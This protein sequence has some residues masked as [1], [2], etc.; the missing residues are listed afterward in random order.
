MFQFV[1]YYNRVIKLGNRR[2][3]FSDEQVAEINEARKNNKDKN[4]ERRLT[5]LSMKA[6][7]KTLEE[8]VVRTAY[9]PDYARSLVTK[10]FAKGLESIIGKKRPGN[11]RN[12]S[13]EE[14]SAFINSFIERARAGELITVKDIKAAYEAKVG[15]KIGSGHIYIIL[16]RHGWRKIKPRPVHPKKATEVEIETSKKLTL[17]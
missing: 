6:S 14:E 15:H 7:G 2:I 3:V 11:H 5:V 9:N 12:M 13:V 16:K 17:A 1:L 4:V 8:I 10:Y